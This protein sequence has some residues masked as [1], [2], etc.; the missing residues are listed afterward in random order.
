MHDS[1][2]T[3]EEKP[4]LTAAELAEETGMTVERIGAM[5]EAGILRPAAADRFEHDDVLRVLVAGAMDDAGLTLELLQRGI[6]LGIVSFEQT[7]VIYPDP[8]ARSRRTVADLADELE[9]P[10]EGLLRIITAFGLPRPDPGTHLHVPD[11]EQLRSFVRAWQPLGGEEVLLRAARSYGDA[12][13]RAAEGWMGIFQEIVVEPVADRAVPWS[14]MSERTLGP[15]LPVLASGRQM[16]NWLLDQ[17]QTQSLNQV[18]FESVE[19]MLGFLG[20][21]VAPRAPAAI[22]FADLAGYTRLTEERGDV[23]AA[24]A[25]TR[26]ATIADAIAARHEGRLVKLLGDG[27]MLHFARPEEALPAALELRGAM[28]PARLPAAHIGVHAGP[29]IRRESDYFGRTV[30]VAARLAAQAGPGEILVTPELLDAAG[31]LPPGV[32]APEPMAPLDLK[33]IPEPVAALRIPP[34]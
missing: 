16:V 29:V 34:A 11:E 5:V 9:M 1:G 8:G 10:V 17:H 12:M 7:P 15:G 25:A 30:N 27:V 13:R 24:D 18:N 22:V 2:V 31:S 32:S 3:T 21:T 28:E 19:R 23:V 14:E 6:E 33:G 20:V 26:L 4:S